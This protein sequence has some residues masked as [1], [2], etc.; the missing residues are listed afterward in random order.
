MNVCDKCPDVRLVDRIESDYMREFDVSFQDI[1]HMG[2]VFVSQPINCAACD[3]CQVEKT[4]CANNM[5][6]IAV[7]LHGTKDQWGFSYQSELGHAVSVNRHG[8]FDA[9]HI[10]S[11]YP[12]SEGH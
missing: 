4:G 2:A 7:L 3:R 5:R 10:R 12:E 8:D 11:Y 9:G 1:H 6:R